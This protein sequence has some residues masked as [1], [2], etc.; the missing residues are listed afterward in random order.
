MVRKLEN[1]SSFV[2][3]IT[4]QY[5]F[6]NFTKIGSSVK[7]KEFGNPN[8]LEDLFPVGKE[9]ALIDDAVKSGR[10]FNNTIRIFRKLGL[11]KIVGFFCVHRA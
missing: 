5:T 7:A 3:F 2:V 4:D 9:I 1:G 8:E 6:F 11:P 10:T